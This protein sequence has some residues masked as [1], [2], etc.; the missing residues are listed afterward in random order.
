MVTVLAVALAGCGGPRAAA[1]RTVVWSACSDGLEC[2][3]LAVP[4]DYTADDGLTQH[5][6]V[7]RARATDESARIGVLFFNPG[8]PGAASVDT[9]AGLRATL[10]DL[11]PELVAKFDL[12]A[13]D[14]RGIGASTPR[15]HYLKDTTLDALRSLDPASDDADARAERDAVADDV[16]AS[17]RRLD[18]R[19][20]THVDTESVARDMDGLRAALGEH[21]V[22]F[23]GGSYGTRLGALYATLF[24]ERVRAFVLDSPVPPSVDRLEL[25]RAQAEGY[26]AAFSAF[27]A[28]CDS[29]ES[30]AL[31]TRDPSEVPRDGAGWAEAARAAFASDTGRTSSGADTLVAIGVELIA[32]TRAWPGLARQ[33]DGLLAGDGSTLLAVADAYY[34][35]AADGVYA[36]HIVDAY[37]AISALDSPFPPGFDR[38]AFDSYVEEQVIPVGPTFGLA[39]ADAERV[40]IGWPFERAKP[41]PAID[42]R[43]APPLL[44]LAGIHDPATPAVWAQDLRDALANGSLLVTNDDYAHGQFFANGCVRD[45]A[46]K[47]LLDPTVPL[48]VSECSAAPVE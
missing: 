41:L 21:A 43:T 19:F 18:P 15:L 24:P 29:T 30:C 14:P 28:W 39:I 1:E 5:I 38:A 27:W 8:G 13:F 25:V 12:V 34:G 16:L 47:F 20:G 23:L 3:T 35:R 7:A 6:A 46:L 22:S 37:T 45:Q 11:A 44:V 10:A 48:G 26:E 32:G 31:R 40:S 42:G 2:A 17:A 4:N 9:L 33:L 36:D